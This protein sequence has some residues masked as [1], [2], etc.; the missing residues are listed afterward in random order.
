MNAFF[1]SHNHHNAT[2][3]D[4]DLD[5]AE[6][7]NRY[8]YSIFTSSDY[9]LPDTTHLTVPVNHLD[10]INLTEQE[11]IDTLNNL[12]P[13]K[14]RGIDI[15]PVILKNCTCA[16]SLALPIHHLF[17]ISLRSGN[18]PSEWKTHKIIPVFKSGDKTSVANYQPISLLCVISKVLERLVYDKVINTIAP[19]ITPHQFGFQ[20][21]AST[22]Q[23]LLIYF[24]QLITSRE[25]I[26]TIYIDFRKA[27][28]SVPRN[29]LLVKLW[30]IGIT[31]TLWNWF[32]SYLSNRSQCVSVENH[33]SDCLPVISGVPQGSI[34]GPLLFLIFINDLPSTIISQLLKFADDTK[35]FRQII[36]ILDIQQLQEDLNSLFNWTINNHL[37][38]N[39]SKFV[40]MS[41]HHK[42]NSQYIRNDHI[43]N[44]SPSCKDL[45]I[46]FTNSLSWRKH[47][48]MISCPDCNYCLCA[49]MIPPGSLHSI[50][51]YFLAI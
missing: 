13:N 46:I 36:S 5:K 28:D 23:Q 16:F 26:D 2:T 11:V 12:N 43:I 50:K 1:C 37:S 9:C 6:L 17:T 38:F 39:L 33:L 27:F 4:A 15:A 42:F 51:N 7:F 14:A 21:N 20:S 32:N 19:S 45:G 44:E 10:S 41:F 49:Y 22:Q 47:Y 34:L 29:E 40:F 3:T 48:E 8:F 35:C 30:N 31:G 18:L 25:E 24:H